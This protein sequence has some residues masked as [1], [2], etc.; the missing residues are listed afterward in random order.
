[1]KG[2][3]IIPLVAL[4]AMAA[5]STLAVAPA[6]HADWTGTII[7]KVVNADG[8]P[9]A[10]V[11]VDST[12]VSGSNAGPNTDDYY[13]STDRNGVY[14]IQVRQN[15]TYSV[16]P[17]VSGTTPQNVAATAGSVIA[18]PTFTLPATTST[19]MAVP[20]DYSA[21][22]SV[23]GGVPTKDR[24]SAF[25]T[26]T[27]DWTDAS[28]AT[29]GRFYFTGLTAGNYKIE[30]TASNASND[31]LG[32][33]WSGGKPN[34]RDATVV[35]IGDKTDL[36]SLSVPADRQAGTITGTIAFP[37][38]AGFDEWNSSVTFYSP[39]GHSFFGA[40]IWAG[41]ASTDAA[42]NFSIDLA[43]GTYYATAQGFATQVTNFGD[44]LNGT[45]ATGP[46][47]DVNVLAQYSTATAW[48]GGRT[49]ALAKKIVVGPNGTVTGINFSLTNTL[50]PVEKP[51]IRGKFKQGKRI[52]VTPGTWNQIDDVTFTYLWKEGAK[53]LGTSPSLKLSKKIW[54]KAK[55]LTVTVTAHDK[56]GLLFD[57]AVTLNVAK[58]IKAQVKA[59]KQQL[60]KD[61][62]ADNK[63]LHQASTV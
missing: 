25:N 42:G 46:G 18:G 20:T 12:K 45:A 6:A 51:M 27:G 37:R 31:F 23:A 38:V 5:G 3:R 11:E 54:K 4:G 32:T 59:A 13:A 17:T 16:A 47:T 34:Q 61:T 7:G 29:D 15:A 9:A 40:G 50:Q 58:T 53:V 36:G 49:M 39:D 22:I 30:A 60:K 28:L 2:R 62:K 63:A 35:G 57:G 41:Q 55:R 48:Y 8:T 14:R 52:S 56:D 43:P 1:M 10:H 21:V 24:A 33:V 44:Q 19:P 26:A